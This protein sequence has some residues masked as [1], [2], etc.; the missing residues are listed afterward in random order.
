[1]KV[2]IVSPIFDYEVFSSETQIPVSIAKLLFH[3]GVKPTVFTT[4]SASK[5]TY[6]KNFKKGSYIYQGIDILRFHPDRDKKFMEFKIFSRWLSSNIHSS[7]DET[8]WFYQ[9][10]PVSNELIKTILSVEEQFDIF[11]FYGIDSFLTYKLSSKIKTKKIL[12]P[13]V[14]DET[15]FEIRKFKEILKNFD[16]FI[17]FSEYERLKLGENFPEILKK[18][19]L[20]IELPTMLP[21]PFYAEVSRNEY[22]LPAPYI[23]YFGE[24]SEKNFISKLVKYFLFYIKRN[25]AELNLVLVGD[26][27]MPL[28]GHEKLYYVK[29]KNAQQL[30]I[31]LKN[32]LLTVHPEEKSF[33]TDK[34]YNSILFGK[35]FIATERNKAFSEVF[36][37]TKSGF[38]YFDFFDFEETLNTLFRNQRIIK[39]LNLKAKEYSRKALEIEKI[40]E[41][42]TLFLR[43]T[44]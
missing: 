30:K 43:N 37:A 8:N 25:F 41:E 23:V 16:G 36:K 7:R 42:L 29:E 32:S 35:P 34:L 40:G 28:V 12:I 14:E 44:L 11:I 38:L 3:A 15:V 33:F 26:I 13:A 6:R 5:R 4:T 39:K 19:F 1:M 18:S 31:I 27:K 21:E 10:G 22:N 20:K 9:S 2:A 17:F 24:V